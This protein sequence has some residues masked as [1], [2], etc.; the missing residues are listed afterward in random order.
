MPAAIVVA[1]LQRAF[2][3]VPAVQGVDLEVGEG[4]IYGFLGPNGAGKTPAR[5]YEQG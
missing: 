3:E 1:G 5:D 2:G 4:E